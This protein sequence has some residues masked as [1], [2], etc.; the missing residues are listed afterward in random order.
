M[1]EQIPIVK[2]L[3]TAIIIGLT[4][5][6]VLFLPTPIFSKALFSMIG[7]YM[8]L[9]LWGVT[10]AIAHGAAMDYAVK[11][12]E[13]VR[14]SKLGLQTYLNFPD[15]SMKTLAMFG[16]I[17]SSGLALASVLS[18]LLFKFGGYAFSR[19]GDRLTSP[20]QSAGAEAGAATATAEG[21]DKS[22]SALRASAASIGAI[23][24]VPF[25][26]A[27]RSGV[28]EK[29][30]NIGKGA[31]IQNLADGYFGGDA[32]SAGE[33]MGGFGRV[34]T[35]QGA[36][37]VGAS[38]GGPVS[39]NLHSGFEESFGSSDPQSPTTSFH[40]P[41]LGGFGIDATNAWEAQKAERLSNTNEAVQTSSERFSNAQQQVERDT[42]AL[43]NAVSNSHQFSD[44]QKQEIA[45]GLSNSSSV[46]D[47][48]SDRLS[49]EHGFS[50]DRVANAVSSMSGQIGAKV[51]TG[52]LLGSFASAFIGGSYEMGSQDREQFG[53]VYKAM[54]SEERSQFV[55]S[56]SNSNAAFSQAH[57]IAESQNDA[58]VMSALKNHETSF[59]SMQSASQDYSSA[60]S[61]RESLERSWSVAEKS[62]LLSKEKLDGAFMQYWNNNWEKYA[63]NDGYKKLGKD[64]LLSDAV[65]GYVDAK[66]VVGNA[67]DDF[68]GGYV[69]DIMNSEAGRTIAGT[70]IGLPE[71]MASPAFATGNQDVDNAIR[72]FYDRSGGVNTGIGPVTQKNY[73]RIAGATAGKANPDIEKTGAA[74]ENYDGMK[75]AVAGYQ[76]DSKLKRMGRHI[77]N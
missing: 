29:T 74:I 63:P 21:L 46:R 25:D 47:S 39:S 72:K 37:Q 14:Q 4:P 33:A 49:K 65:Q 56:V 20:V 48:I 45:K 8:F 58:S 40:A 62:G 18:M 64:T 1:N 41:N 77:G 16:M 9:T 30:A 76:D 73:E 68:R 34:A 27:V 66:R 17:R 32:F 38:S 10:D 67:I 3:M 23:G 54:T 55:E 36:G 75:Q 50:K 60:L 57:N 26:T 2:A 44:A 71:Q 69:N 59:S 43:S 42:S 22:V 28:S 19:M 15:I 11:T 7:F 35:A 31:G 51:S 12:F 13:V 24:N 70:D 61:Q 6:L 5:I 52:G 53:D